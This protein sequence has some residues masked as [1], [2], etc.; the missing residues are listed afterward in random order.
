MKTAQRSKRPPWQKLLAVVALLSLCIRIDPEGES[1]QPRDLKWI[2]VSVFVLLASVGLW[3]WALGDLRLI[4]FGA[5]CA[6]L[7][8]YPINSSI[9][10]IS[11]NR[12][13]AP[14]AEA[15]EKRLL[16]LYDLY[17]GTAYLNVALAESGLCIGFAN[18][19]DTDWPMLVRG[20][21]LVL[22]CLGFFVR[23][24]AVY[25]TGLDTYFYHDLFLGRSVMHSDGGSELVLTGPYRYF[26]NPMYGFGYVPAYGFALLC[27]SFQGLFVAL[28]F[29][30]SI[31]GFYFFV[32]KP[33][34]KRMYGLD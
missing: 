24:W 6:W 4:F 2:C 14:T 23:G 5:I 10:L 30:A 19:L 12:A 15:D 1:G 7:F 27:L 29:H 32:E 3:N 11:K 25:L 17:L 18:T 33:F 16:A 34:V 28:F 8:Y 26:K 20:V 9:L 13:G 31:Y 21:G 22:M